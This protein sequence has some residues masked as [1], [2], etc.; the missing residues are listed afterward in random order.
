MRAGGVKFDKSK[1]WFYDFEDEAILFPRG[2]HDDQVDALAYVGLIV[3]KLL[4][5]PTEKQIA[6]EEYEEELEQSG[7]AHAGRST[8]TGY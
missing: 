1:E 7:L 2:K 3:D 6:D 8:T 5:A 4:H